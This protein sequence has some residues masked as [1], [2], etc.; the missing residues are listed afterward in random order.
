MSTQ[1]VQ[2]T[3]KEDGEDYEFSLDDRPVESLQ[4]LHSAQHLQLNL[5][6]R[7]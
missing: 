2:N 1:C 4:Q 6:P 5:I 3:K 7:R